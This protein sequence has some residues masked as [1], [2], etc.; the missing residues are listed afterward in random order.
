MRGGQSWKYAPSRRC[1]VGQRAGG[2]AAARQKGGSSR[3]PQ[4]A[5]SAPASPQHHGAGAI[6][7]LDT[8]YLMNHASTFPASTF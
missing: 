4:R 1:V 6:T 8:S 7:Q 5:P 3:F 2:E